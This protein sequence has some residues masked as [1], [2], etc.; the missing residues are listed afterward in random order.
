[1]LSLKEE[2]PVEVPG[3]RGGDR[4][5]LELPEVQRSLLAALHAAGKKVVF[6]NF[7]GSAMG[8][9]PETESCDAILQAWYPGEEGGN[10]IADVLLGEV[11]PSGKLPLTF[12]KN[13]EQ[14]PDFEDYSMKGRTYRYF[15]GEPLFPFGFGLSYTTFEYGSAFVKGHKLIVPVTNS[16]AIDAEEV[17]QLYVRRPDDADGPLKSLRGFQR[18]L[19]PAGETV[20]VAFTLNDETFLNWSPDAQ[21][22]IPLR[23]SWDLLV[24][25]SSADLQ[26]I[27]FEL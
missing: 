16:G 18:V 19:I 5:S 13:V 27:S 2:M 17:V 1:M 24:G 14:L 6:V 20:E 8:L 3:F 9:V 4:T 10:A 21:D 23:G 26:C 7:S 25:G 22:M 12:Y 15:E 11:S